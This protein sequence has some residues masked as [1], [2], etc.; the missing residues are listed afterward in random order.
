MPDMSGGQA[1][2]G[3]EVGS[4]YGCCGRSFLTTEEKIEML[5]EYEKSLELEM[6]GVKERIDALQ[7]Q[8]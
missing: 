2:M 6:K 5:K 1:V 7:K 3:Q 8:N 4:M